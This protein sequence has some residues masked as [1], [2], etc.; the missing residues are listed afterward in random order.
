MC[1]FLTGDDACT[2]LDAQSASL[3]LC[4]REEICVKPPSMCD[5]LT[6]DNACTHLDA[7]STLF[8]L[9]HSRRNLL[10]RPEKNRALGSIG[11]RNKSPITS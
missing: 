5:F 8:V 10:T 9:V 11:T 6:D 2:H 7:Q 4:I 1:D 3:F